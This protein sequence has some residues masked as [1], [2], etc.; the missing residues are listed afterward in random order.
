MIFLLQPIRLIIIFVCLIASNQLWAFGA[1]GH[2]VVAEI[3]E[4][5]LS[6]KAKREIMKITNGHSLA[7]MAIWADLIKSNSDWDY[8][9]P[10][11]YLSIDD[12][13]SF[14][15]Y[16]HDTKG[17]V[18]VALEKFEKELKEQSGSKEEIWQALAFYIHFTGDIH[19][20]LHVGRRDDR[21]GNS[22]AVKWFDKESNLH[23]V[24]DSGIIDNSELSYSE[25]V[26]FLDHASKDQIK[27]WQ[28]STYWDWAKDSKSIRDQ[29][30]DYGKQSSLNYPSLSYQYIYE[31]KPL[32]EE[33]MLKAGVRLAGK[34]NDIFE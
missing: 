6:K 29:V 4:N 20:P 18:I 31:T 14:E 1:S 11:H 12:N 13:E 25:Y 2:R 17:D 15:G 16:K 9:K 10:W 34:L 28:K 3:A 5:H 27:N 32:L 33:Q 26:T 22:I 7:S 24:W 19:Q 8:A 23:S 21:G 30:Y